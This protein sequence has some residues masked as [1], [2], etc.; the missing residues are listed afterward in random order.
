MSSDQKPSLGGLKW[1]M[2]VPSR[3]IEQ[4]QPPIQQTVLNGFGEMVFLDVFGG[5]EVGDGAGDSS[6]LV[7]SAGAEAE[8]VHGLLHQEQATV[9]QVAVLL[10]LA[11]VHAGV[12]GLGFEALLLRG[13]GAFYL[14]AHGGGGGAGL[15]AGELAIGDG[16]DFDVD[17]D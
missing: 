13:A 15:F 4:S 17:V 1:A 16:G 6:D 14:F 7:I 11:A 5:F 8:L 9:R 12:G 2:S 3:R 10:E